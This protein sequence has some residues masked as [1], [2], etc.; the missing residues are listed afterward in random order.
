MTSVSVQTHIS[1]D[2]L[3]FRTRVS[4]VQAKASSSSQVLPA[5]RPTRRGPAPARVTGLHKAVGLSAFSSSPIVNMNEIKTLNKKATRT[6]RRQQRSASM[7][8]C[9][10]HPPEPAVAI[11]MVAGLASTL[12]SSVNI[13]EGWQKLQ[14]IRT[15]EEELDQRELDQIRKMATEHSVLPCPSS[16]VPAVQDIVVSRLTELV[17]DSYTGVGDT[18]VAFASPSTGKTTAFQC[19]TNHYF[20]AVLPNEDT[21]SLMI[22]R[23]RGKLDGSYCSHIAKT[24]GIRNENDVIACLLESM[25]TKSESLAS[26][27]VLDEF[28]DPGEGGCNLVLANGL[29]REIAADDL[30][31][32]LYIVTQDKKVAQA[33]IDMN[34]WSKIGPMEGL[35]TPKRSEVLRNKAQVPKGDVWTTP[36]WSQGE[37]TELVRKEFPNLEPD[38]GGSYSWIEEGMVPLAV[39]RLAKDKTRSQDFPRIGNWRGVIDKNKA[40]VTNQDNNT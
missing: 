26:I 28:N 12:S 32:L 20:P 4:L 9:A 17:L 37:L 30:G 6:V 29:M 11:E 15:G 34:N 14:K 39:K 8:I 18:Q 1:S 16:G 19:L 23:Y 36:V 13:S 22:T 38:R 7:K 24:L 5:R 3:C 2:V 25:K 10:A 33:L 27:L 31:I 21:K 35:T 40:F